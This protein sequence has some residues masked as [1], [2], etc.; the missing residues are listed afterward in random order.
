MLADVEDS[1]TT[2]KQHWLNVLCLLCV[3]LYTMTQR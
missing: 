3:Q 1:G 2:L